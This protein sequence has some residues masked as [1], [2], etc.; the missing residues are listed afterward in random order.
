MF[1]GV[2][3]GLA[4]LGTGV[5]AGGVW[6]FNHRQAART[7]T[8]VSLGAKTS[9]A[10]VVGESHTASE[11]ASTVAVTG[12][13]DDDSVVQ[14]TNPLSQAHLPTQSRSADGTEA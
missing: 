13:A 10:P 3:V 6:F 14:M 7:G 8:A 4:V 5:V 12:P 9:A 1:I 11:G 2:M